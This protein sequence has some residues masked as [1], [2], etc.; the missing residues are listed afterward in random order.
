MMSEKQAQKFYTGD[1]SLLQVKINIF[2]LKS[3]NP[4]LILNFLSLLALIIL[5]L[6]LGGKGNWESTKVKKF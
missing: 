4:R 1:M 2:R 5:E 3:F 6:G